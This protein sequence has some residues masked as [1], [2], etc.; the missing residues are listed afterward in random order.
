MGPLG[1]LADRVRGERGEGR[2]AEDPGGQA[3]VDPH[4]RRLVDHD[5]SVP[6]GVLEHLLGIGVVRGAEGV[7]PEPL[8][9][10]EVVNHKH[11]VVALAPHG[12]VFVP[13]EAAEVEGLPV[14]EE[15]LS[16]HLHGPD[17]D[18]K[19]VGVTRPGVVPPEF[20]RELVQVALTRAPRAHVG[21]RDL[22]GV[23]LRDGDLGAFRISER[24]LDRQ[25]LRV[26]RVNV[27][28]DRAP[29]TVEPGDD[30]DVGDVGERRR[31]Q[32]NS[33]V[34]SGVVEEVKEKV[35]PRPV[36]SLDHVTRRDGI[37]SEDAVDDC[38]DAMLAAG[39]NEVGDLGL[40]RREPALML[41]H[42]L[43]VDPDGRAVGG[44]AEAQHDPLAGPARRHADGRLVPHLANV[45]VHLGVSEDVVVAGGDGHL[46]R[47][48]RQAAGPVARTTV[49]VG[50]EREPPQP[51]QRL[52][53]TGRCV[54]W[55][56]HLFSYV[57]AV[58]R[59]CPG[60]ARAVTTISS[61]HVSRGTAVESRMR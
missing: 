1:G 14:N 47:L 12:G 43:T 42:L 58:F 46:S 36:R 55:C 32:P 45:V 51:V 9:E 37:P 27:V 60:W 56:Q 10:R 15:A 41:D 6:V 44:R 24:Y 23:T 38:G 18:R 33:P 25:V 53:L 17:T 22:A 11:I 8:H 34:Q 5:D 59:G 2:G 20:D 52:T 31:V 29:R 7:R 39:L 50:V 13:A 54:S 35:L 49:A 19:C 40:E 16:A 61:T 21:D 3:A 4:A 57:G 26:H 30:G 28:T 48:A